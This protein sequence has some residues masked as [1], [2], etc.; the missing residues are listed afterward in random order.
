M[1][2][3]LSTTKELRGKKPAEIDAYIVE[4]K[5]TLAELRREVARNQDNKTHQISLLK[6]TIARAQT[7]KTAQ[8]ISKG[9][10]S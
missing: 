2:L 3:K 1:K 6:K 9:K 10:E 4:M 5:N 7:V 8:V